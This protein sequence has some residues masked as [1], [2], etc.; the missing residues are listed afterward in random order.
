MNTMEIK[1][2]LEKFN[3]LIFNKDIMTLLLDIKV[4]LS[5]IEKVKNEAEKEKLFQKAEFHSTIIGSDTGEKIIAMV[6]DSIQKE[7]ITSDI[8]K[9]SHEFSWSYSQK[10]EYYFIS[11][12]YQEN[13]DEERK[14]IIQMIDLPD[15]VP[16]Y[17]KLNK[18]LGTNFDIPLPHITLFTT[19]TNPEKKLRGVGIYSKNQ[20]D[21]LQPKIIF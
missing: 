20:F 14:S 17:E 1:N 10:D 3:G 21:A 8:E 4:N 7:K 9:L 2:N 15:I 19:S 11:K 18:K 13:E 16:F 5:S 6:A 12:K